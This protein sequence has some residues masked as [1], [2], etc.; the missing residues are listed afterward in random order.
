MF[1]GPSYYATN[2]VTFVQS[3]SPSLWLFVGELVQAGLLVY[4]WSRVMAA[5]APE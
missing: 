2:A 4:L 3:D 1:L 5:S